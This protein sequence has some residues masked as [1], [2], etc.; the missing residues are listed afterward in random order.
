MNIIPTASSTQPDGSQPK[1]IFL[2]KIP[3]TLSDSGGYQIYS[4][5]ED[6]RNGIGPKKC[7][8]IPFVGIKKTK[9]VLILDP[10]DLCQKY[11][12]LGIDYGF[13]L[14]YPLSDNFSNREYRINLEKSYEMGRI[15]VLHT[16][17]NVPNNQFADPSPLLHRKPTTT[18]LPYHVKIKPDWLR[19]TGEAY[20]HL[21]V[22]VK[23]RV[24]PGLPAPQKGEHCPFVRKLQNRD[25]HFRG[26]SHQIENVPTTDI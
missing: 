22:Y 26:S 9:G 19:N 15:D 8:V 10:I 18:L 7:I 17:N 4:R 20:R 2:K 16:T 6:Y 14:D 1:I 21:G 25:H 24:R 3:L 23:E 12:E 5:N 11:G 13:T